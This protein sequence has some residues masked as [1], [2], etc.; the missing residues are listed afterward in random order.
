MSVAVLQLLLLLS[1]SR[2]GFGRD[3]D[4][5]GIKPSFEN[6]HLDTNQIGIIIIGFFFFVG[7][8]RMRDAAMR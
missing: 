6:M 5:S 4:K 8:R 7:V 2:E 3:A 1:F